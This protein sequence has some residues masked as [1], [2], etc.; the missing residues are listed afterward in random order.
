MD[1]KRK[2]NELDELRIIYKE[3]IEGCSFSHRGSFFIK[4]L[5]E[6]EQI[7][8]TRKRISFIAKYVDRGIPTEEE[9]LKRIKDDGEWTDAKDADIVA[10]RQT[11]SDN[12]R[13]VATIIPQQQ[14]AIKKI[15]EDHRKELIKL[16]VERRQ[17]IGTTAEELA[18]KD[19]TYYTAF[20]TIYKD[21]AC[22]QPV[23]ERWEDFEVLEEADSDAYLD[24]IDE[25]LVRLKEQN[26]RRIS[27][28]PFF[29]NTFS[30]S[31]ERV[32]TFLGKPICQLTNFQVHLFSLG[33]RNLNILTQAEGSPPEYYEKENVDE[34]IKWYDLQ[35]SII[36]TKRKG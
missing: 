11:I 6:L 35:Y 33:L 34:I 17:T 4:H 14:G 19:C 32:N 15:I 3:I 22:K 25:T 30:Y 18:D 28:L 23:F 9:R 31:K 13:M 1:D 7:E 12:E 36:L 20:L 24:S 5:C 2:V 21:G 26:I 8:I 27:C 16:L 10:Y 29:L